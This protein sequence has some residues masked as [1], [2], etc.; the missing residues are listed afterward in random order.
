[1]LQNTHKTLKTI[2]KISV[3]LKHSL[4]VVLALGFQLLFFWIVK[5]VDK[6]RVFVCD[7]FWE[8]KNFFY[9][10]TVENKCRL[11]WQEPLVRWKVWIG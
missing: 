6:K 7:W 4:G 1:M 2:L 10:L 5:Y 9:W 8:N 3:V 11:R